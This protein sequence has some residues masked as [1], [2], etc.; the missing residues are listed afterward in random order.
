ML[1]KKHL[2]FLNHTTR[3]IPNFSQSKIARLTGDDL[4]GKTVGAEN[5]TSSQKLPEETKRNMVNKIKTF[6]MEF[7]YDKTV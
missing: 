6:S 2:I 3:I 1:G 7:M 4:Q 5:G